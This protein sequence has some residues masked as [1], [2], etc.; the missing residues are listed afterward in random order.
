MTLPAISYQSAESSGL[1]YSRSISPSPEEAS[2]P[3]G[4]CGDMKSLE[5]LKTDPILF[6]LTILKKNA[7]G[8]LPERSDA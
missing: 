2:S 1:E 7:D 6:D 4:S 8:A 3:S 5:S